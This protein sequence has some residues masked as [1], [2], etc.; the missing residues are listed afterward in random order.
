MYAAE[1]SS[2][3]EH[4]RGKGSF[5]EPCAATALAEWPKFYRNGTISVQHYG[6]AV[7][8]AQKFHFSISQYYICECSSQKGYLP[9]LY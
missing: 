8:R 7:S 1:H 5:Q 9:R 2:L 3:I 4:S 6:K